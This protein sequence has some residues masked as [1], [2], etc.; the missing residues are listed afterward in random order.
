M[1]KEQK[2]TYEELSRRLEIAESGIQAMR[3]HEA[4]LCLGDRE[5][6]AV[7][8]AETEACLRESENKFKH[9]FEYSPVGISITLPSGDIQV[10]RAFYR[11]LG[12]AEAETPALTWSQITHPD[13]VESS[14]QVVNALLSGEKDS[15]RFVKRYIREDSSVVWADVS[16]TIR[17]DR[18]GHPFFFVTTVNDITELRR[19]RERQQELIDHRTFELNTRMAEVETLNRALAN[20]L[21][22]LQ[23]ANRNLEAARSKLEEV[24][25]EL[26][27]FAYVV[28]HDLKA[29][30]RG[31]SQLATWIIEDYADALDDEG[32][33]KLHLLDDRVKRMHGL[34]DG[35]LQYSRIG[36]TREEQRP[37]TLERL[38][39]GVIELLAPPAHIRVS[40]ET[41]LPVVIGEPTQLRQVFQNLVDNGIKFMDKPEG[42]IAIGCSAEA[43]T[44]QFYVADNGPGIEDKH[45]DR[46]FRLFQRLFDQEGASGTGVGLAL[47][48][49]I[50]EKRGGRVWVESTP[51]KGSTFWFTLPKAIDG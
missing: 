10:N 7:R 24:N 12:Y 20:M 22:D 51:G 5:T 27:D 13:D 19:H 3:G 2:P 17:R 48:K 1:V 31:I 11:M 37:V 29:P 50:V 15:A 6:L 44:W 14:Q 9:V 38:V 26:E 35:V 39:R 32:R 25:L 36:R 30:L 47:V 21:E 33:H 34:I 23:A 41:P 43:T 28:S 18:D 4:H 40:I 45:F 46:I 16:T 42:R 8:L 49:R